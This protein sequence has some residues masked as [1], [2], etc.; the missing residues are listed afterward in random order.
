MDGIIRNHYKVIKKYKQI[1]EVNSLT[2]LLI[3]KTDRIYFY[4]NI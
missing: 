1:E 4:E 3:G 2:H